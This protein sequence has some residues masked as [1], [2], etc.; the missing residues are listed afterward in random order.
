MLATT[1]IL[2]QL[3]FIRDNKGGSNNF[4][5][6][7]AHTHKQGF[8]KL[9]VCVFLFGHS[10]VPTV[11]TGAKNYITLVVFCVGSFKHMSHV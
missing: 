11:Y 9:K 6:L 10:P 4:P 3:N 2:Y 5:V 8:Y 7:Y 1:D